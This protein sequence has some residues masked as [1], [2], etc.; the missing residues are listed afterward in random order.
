MIC[1]NCQT[2]NIDGA[3]FCDNCGK[4][5]FA[6]GPA[7]TQVA[8]PPPMGS[9]MQP[10]MPASSGSVCPACGTPYLPGEMFCSNCGSPLSAPVPQQSSMP[11]SFAP[12]SPQP[13]P[14]QSQAPVPPPASPVPP[15]MPVAPAMPTG[16]QPYLVVVSNGTQ[17][18]LPAKSEILVGRLDPVSGVYPDVDLTPYGAD[19]CGVS[20]RHIKITFAGNQYFIEDLNST[21]YTH[22]GSTKI[23]PGMRV[24]LNSGDQLR[25][26]KL[27]LNFYAG[28]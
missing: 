15:T 20:R 26:G 7:P 17:L 16:G 4:A 23:Q 21:N 28:R 12:V 10:T 13:T 25:L 14:P 19:E 27:L 9:P 6:A 2:E 5:L 18:T 22:I 11:S 24:P 8:A 1:P 3:A